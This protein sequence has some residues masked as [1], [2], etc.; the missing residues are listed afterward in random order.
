M[1][2]PGWY[3]GEPM[4]NFGHD[5]NNGL[6]RGKAAGD[7]VPLPGHLDDK[8]LNIVLIA[9]PAGGGVVDFLFDNRPGGLISSV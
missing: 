1:P 7:D 3:K 9:T 8:R 2:R 5:M 6:R 4:I